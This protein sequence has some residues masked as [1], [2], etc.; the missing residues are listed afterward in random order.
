MTCATLAGNVFG[1][2]VYA[3]T[4]IG[5]PPVLVR[6]GAS[7]TGLLVAD[8][9]YA[10][11]SGQPMPSWASAFAEYPTSRRYSPYDLVFREVRNRG[12][13]HL[14][15]CPDGPIHGQWC[16]NYEVVD[17]THVRV[18]LQAPP[19]YDSE[20]WDVEYDP[21]TERYGWQSGSPLPTP[22]RKP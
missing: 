1:G 19:G 6:L 18:Q 5:L 20:I 4:R 10:P 21:E 8:G 13:S 12:L 16:T 17:P 2:Q 22:G 11:L 15:E 3:V 7:G 9:S 14:I